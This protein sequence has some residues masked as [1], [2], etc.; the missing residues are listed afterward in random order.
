MKLWVFQVLYDSLKLELPEMKI[1]EFRDG[2]M[3]NFMHA[4]VQSNFVVNYLTM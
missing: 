2:S 4:F 1:L 3:N